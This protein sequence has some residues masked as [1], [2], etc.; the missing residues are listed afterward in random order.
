MNK[1]SAV[2]QEKL[3]VATAQFVATG[4]ASANV[5]ASVK[6]DHLIK[7]GEFGAWLPLPPKTN[8]RRSALSGTSVTFLTTFFKTYLLSESLD[9]LSLS[10]RKGGVTDLEGFFPPSKQNATELSTHF[11]SAGLSGVVDFYVKQK[12]GQATQD[13]LKRLKEF[14]AEEADF[15][16]VSIALHLHQGVG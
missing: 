15:D 14:I 4:L 8:V 6:K 12:S 5:L 7:D 2:D 1:F 9:H 16:E 13:M 3:A 11:K 10:L